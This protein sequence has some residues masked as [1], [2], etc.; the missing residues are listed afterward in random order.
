MLSSTIC[1]FITEEMYQIGKGK[2]YG[3]IILNSELYFIQ[4]IVYIDI[5]GL[6]K[7]IIAGTSRD[8]VHT[9]KQT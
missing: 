2:Y 4:G 7:N 9:S 6:H 3:H 8:L 5:F 1:I